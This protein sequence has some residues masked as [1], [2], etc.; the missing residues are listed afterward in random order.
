MVFLLYWH[1]GWQMRR[2][3]NCKGLPKSLEEE[4]DEDVDDQEIEANA[5]AAR[6]AVSQ[7]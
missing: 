7:F 4:E 1:P 5:Q 2:F 6:L 3:A